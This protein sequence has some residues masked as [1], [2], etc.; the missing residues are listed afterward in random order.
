MAAISVWL[1]K[2]YGAWAMLVAPV[3]TGGLLSGFA[4]HN[5]AIFLAWILAYL[6]YMAVRG[7]TNGRRRN[8]YTVAVA[9]YSAATLALLAALLWWRPSLLWWAIP[10]G[11]LLGISLTMIVTGREHSA[12]NDAGLIGA[13]ALMTAVS[14]TAGR[15]P[16]GLGWDGF[17]TAV[18][19]VAPWLATAVLAGYFW[20]TIP[21]VK[22][23]I[24]E[25]GKTRW[26]VGSVVYHCALIVPAFL[27]N[28]WVGAFS[29]ALAARA[30]AVPKLWPRAKPKAI[31][32]AEV[33]GTVAIVVIACLTLK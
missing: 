1:P 6:A 27:V 33:A 12:V 19:S 8:E 7:A 13:S 2:H 4:W 26:Y 5:V 25:R 28:G 11:V 9:V 3:V 24:R 18:Q 17:F 20:G 23:M 32:I 30:A 15:L 21:Y 16:Q 22:T 10:L 29:I 31:G 14:A